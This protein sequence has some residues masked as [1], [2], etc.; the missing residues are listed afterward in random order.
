MRI[1]VIQ[2]L[3]DKLRKKGSLSKRIMSSNDINIPKLIIN[4]IKGIKIG[5]PSWIGMNIA[6]LK[7][8]YVS[9]NSII[10]CNAVFSGA[11]KYLIIL[12]IC[13]KTCSCC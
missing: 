13:R 3:I 12:C 10:G 4:K 8:S 2:E 7:N 6:I 9:L 1:K 11:V 5:K